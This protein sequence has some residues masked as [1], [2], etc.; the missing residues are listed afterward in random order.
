[1]TTQEKNSIVV[2]FHCVQK[3]DT[4]P[5][6]KIMAKKTSVLYSTVNTVHRFLSS[7]DYTVMKLVHHNSVLNTDSSCPKSPRSLLKEKKAARCFLI[8]L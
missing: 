5:F 4:R 2:V 6:E 3:I 8:F 7:S 1:M